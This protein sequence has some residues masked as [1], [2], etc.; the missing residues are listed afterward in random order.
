MFRILTIASVAL[1]VI[2]A[3]LFGIFT[4]SRDIWPAPLIRT[5]KRSLTPDR[6]AEYD[7]F[8]RLIGYPQKVILPCP[9]QDPR[10]AVLLVIGQSNSA[11][12]AEK[13]F[14]TK[15]FG[16]VVNFFDGECYSAESP[17]L[18]ASGDQGEFSTL[19]GDDLIERGVADK[20]VIASSGI[21]YTTIARWKQNSDLNKM[22]LNVIQKLQEK[23][24]ITEVIWHQGESD[25]RSKT[26]EA[27]YVEAF[28]SLLRT[29]RTSG[30][31]APVY[32]AVAT[33][34]LTHNQPW[35]PN[36]PVAAG[37]K[38]IID[39]GLAYLGANTDELLAESDRQLDKCHFSK[40]GQEKTA[41]AFAAAIERS[42][43]GTA[44]TTRAERLE[45]RG[46]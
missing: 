6:I 36:N 35:E 8:N 5:V 24:N 45:L 43:L 7:H 46:P 32:I 37:Q 26:S 17:L 9:R 4:H 40:S 19:L 21:G 34:C 15:Y 39:S 22:M 3:Y 29:I 12:H 18:G 23:Y 44:S 27:D 38:Q 31:A 42:L 16:S 14:T 1:L 25:Y 30:V 20:V 41:N 11:N 28:R 33:K 10:T 13:K 2:S